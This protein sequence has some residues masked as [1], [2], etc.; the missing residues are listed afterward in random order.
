MAESSGLDPQTV[1]Q[2][3][4]AFQ[5]LPNPVGFTLQYLGLFIRSAARYTRL[6]VGI[7]ALEYLIERLS[8]EFGP[9]TCATH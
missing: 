9:L 2:V 1:F 5:A 8:V 3:P 6:S 4:N 7:S